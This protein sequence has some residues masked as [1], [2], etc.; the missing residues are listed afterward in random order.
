[1]ADGPVVFGPTFHLIAE[2]ERGRTDP[3]GLALEYQDQQTALEPLKY[4][5]VVLAESW[6]VFLVI[7]GSMFLG[8]LITAW[9]ELERVSHLVGIFAN[10]F[11]E[12]LL[13]G[14]FYV[15]GTSL[16]RIKPEGTTLRTGWFIF[17][18]I[19]FLSYSLVLL[20]FAV[21]ILTPSQF[22][23]DVED[24]LF[25]LPLHLYAIYSALSIVA[26]VARALV[27]VELRQAVPFSIY[28]GTFLLLFFFPF[29]IWIIQPRVQAIFRE[30]ISHEDDLAGDLI[31]L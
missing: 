3:N 23:F 22:P 11:S 30:R 29:G 18:L 9:A 10:Y 20:F 14:W 27:S 2:G 25:L 19:Y 16:A 13:A 1:M 31:D 21:A 26:F 12:V 4:D 28:G 15:I 7:V 17:N 8:V 6:Q 24:A 5:W